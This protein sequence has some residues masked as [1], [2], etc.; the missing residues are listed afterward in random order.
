MAWHRTSGHSWNSLSGPLIKSLAGLVAALLL[1]L[2]DIAPAI[3]NESSSNTDASVATADSFR[4][5]SNS[6]SDY[7]PT[8]LGNG[9][10]LC[11]TPWDGTAGT[12]AIV[13]GAYDHLDE[14]AFAY[15]ALIPSWNN[16]DYWNGSHWLD[17]LPAASLQSDEYVQ[18]LDMRLGELTTSYRWVDANRVTHIAA[19]EFA[20]RDNPHLA[21]IR[22]QVT[23]E[24]GIEAGPVT[25]SF[26]LGGKL[27]VPFVW[28][29]S[30]LP[31]PIP[32][33]QARADADLHGFV[34]DSETR[35]GKIKVSEAVRLT[36]AENLPPAQRVNL[37]FS[38]DL[39]APALKVKFIAQKGKTYTFTKF[40]GVATSL[41]SRLPA[42]E[43][44]DVAEKAAEEGFDHVRKSHEAAWQKFWQTDILIRG[45]AQAE[46]VV[47]AAMYFLLSA[48]RAGADWS[49]PAMTLPSRAYLGRIWWDADTW[50]F[51]SILV[52]YPSLARSFVDYRCERLNSAEENAR[53]QGYQGALYPMESAG[54]GKEAAPEWSGEIHVTGDV[55][56]AQWRYYQ[57]T[58]DL[59]WL[60]K[61]GYPVLRAVADFW[62]SRAT[63]NRQN[64]R[65]EILDVTG[66][67]EAVENVDNDSY[68]NAIAKR[69]LEAA[70]QAARRVGEVPDPKWEQVS[71]TLW[72]PLDAQREVHLEHSGDVNGNYAHALILMTYPLDMKFS[73]SI[74]RHDLD[75]CLQNYGKPGYEVGML[76]NIYSIVA[77][78]L[79]DRDLA[80]KLFSSLVNSYA[81]KPF[82]DMTETPSNGRAV[83]LTAE[84]AFLQQVIF[85]F[86]GLR[87]T[88]NGLQAEYPPLLPPTWQSLEL[89]GI[90]SRGKSYDVLATSDQKLVMTATGH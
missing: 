40:A 37:A 67:N 3:P 54:S 29:G 39:A 13:T 87:L 49:V 76:G 59:A 45:D 25:V 23:P 62:T 27:G 26:P 75:A 14:N 5:A 78:Q 64:G 47:H 19:V 88:D 17:G 83:F 55:A 66:P 35:D 16:I 90:E 30:R 21:V 41:D 60:R 46:R 6:F 28:E 86:T 80:Y 42:K 34:A 56:M 48:L 8:I 61:C 50:I 24:Y 36:L 58:G 68:T 84:G 65:T 77:S 73:S 44:Q 53:Q 12:E 2:P 15:Q 81:H 32:I 1:V 63:F 70:T 4:F 22:L 79:E 71:Q 85:G 11:S 52:L 57:A 43:A 18:T 31:G 38:S 33:R 74:E 20:S 51:P 69:S 72:I 10:I 82:E 7:T 89:R 9:Y